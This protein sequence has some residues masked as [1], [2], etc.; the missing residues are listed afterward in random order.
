MITLFEASLFTKSNVGNNDQLN[1]LLQEINE[2]RK[3]ESIS[4]TNDLCWRSA[5]KYKNT[6]W[7]IKNIS[8]LVKEASEY[9]N[10]KDQVFKSAFN[11]DNLQIYYW[12]NVN[13]P[14]SRNVIHSHKNAVFSG[15]YYINGT[16]TGGLRIFNPANVLG[17]CNAISPF[18]RDFYFSPKDRDLILWPS[19]LPHEVD[20]NM[21][22][23]ER[24]NI[25]FDIIT[26]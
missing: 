7:L 12:T 9:Y 17:D 21:S 22:Q 14:Y 25:A 15:V 20:V 18:T 6:D 2:E 4:D 24:I 19:W 11:K 23:R 1:L 13:Q 8:S 16:D 26:V 3:N 5:K 10:L